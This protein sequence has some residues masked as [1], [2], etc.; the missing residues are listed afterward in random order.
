M[1]RSFQRVGTPIWYCALVVTLGDDAEVL[2]L[3]RLAGECTPSHRDEVLKDLPPAQP[4]LIAGFIKEFNDPLACRNK[5]LL[6][7]HAAL[8]FGGGGRLLSVR[9]VTALHFSAFGCQP[10]LAQM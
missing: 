7:C 5:E 9:H 10:F 6:I 2:L 1:K 8:P 3:G 4:T